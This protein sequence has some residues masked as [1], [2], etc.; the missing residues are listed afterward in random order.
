M[1]RGWTDRHMDKH[2]AI[3]YSIQTIFK[4]R[5]TYTQTVEKTD[6]RLDEQAD[7]HKERQS[8]SHYGKT[9]RLTNRQ[10]DRWTEKHS[11]N[12]KDRQVLWTDN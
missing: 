9:Y 5:H 2:K 6:R 1:D 11:F 3:D 7:S 8:N 10:T 12:W 4:D